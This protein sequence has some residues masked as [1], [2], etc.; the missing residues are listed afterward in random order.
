MKL[1]NP[2]QKQNWKIHN[3]AET[4]AL[5]KS[6]WVKEKEKI[7]R[8][9]LKYFGTNKKQPIKHY[10]MLKNSTEKEFHSYKCF[11]KKKKKDFK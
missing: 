10:G 9:I 3:Y 6:Q 1:K 5:F 2:Q 4:S 7:T 8:E 11:L